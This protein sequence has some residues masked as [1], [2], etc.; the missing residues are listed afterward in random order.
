MYFEMASNFE[1]LCGDTAV[2]NPPTYI[3]HQIILHNMTQ[4][5]L[6]IRKGAIIGRFKIQNLQD[7]YTYM[8]IPS[9]EELFDRYTDHTTSVVDCNLRFQ[10]S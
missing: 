10:L 4:G 6:D 2:Q 8:P 1:G 5:H 9:N 3:F 7:K